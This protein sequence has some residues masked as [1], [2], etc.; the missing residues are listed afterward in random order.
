ML[1]RKASTEGLNGSLEKGL[2][3]RTEGRKTGE[4]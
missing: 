1:N 3:G 2:N 4:H